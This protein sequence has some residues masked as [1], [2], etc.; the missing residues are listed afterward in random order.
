MEKFNQLKELMN[1]L[2]TE[3][4]SFYVKGNK[5]SARR[6]RKALQ[7]IGKITKDF[8]KEISE[9]VNSLKAQ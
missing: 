2:S 3:V 8:R 5:T 9:R 7:E 4:D 1:S 6:A